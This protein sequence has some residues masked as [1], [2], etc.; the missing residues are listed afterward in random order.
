[1]ARY[2]D[3]KEKQEDLEQGKKGLSIYIFLK[4]I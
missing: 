3:T 2:Q 1:M 4:M